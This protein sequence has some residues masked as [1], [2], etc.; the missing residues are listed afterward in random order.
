[1]HDLR[2]S[3]AYRMA[4][5]PGMPITDVQWILGHSH[6]TTTQIYVTPTEDDVIKGAREHFRRQAVPKPTP[7]PAPGYRAESLGILFGK[8]KP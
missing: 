1:L 5:D 6:L 2:H 8:G 4:Q 7:Q 3:A